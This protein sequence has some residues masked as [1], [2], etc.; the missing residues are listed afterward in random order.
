MRIW[1]RSSGHQTAT[2]RSIGL[3]SSPASCSVLSHGAMLRL[4]T[5]SIGRGSRT[6]RFMMIIILLSLSI[7][8]TESALCLLAEQDLYALLP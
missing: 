7:R 2:P 5:P 3:P 8:V 4:P 1:R 6:L